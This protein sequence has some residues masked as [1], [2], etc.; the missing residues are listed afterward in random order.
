M[1]VLDASALLK[2]VVREHGWVEVERLLMRGCKTLHIA[3]AEVAMA[4]EVGVKVG[5][6]DREVALRAVKALK[7][8]VREG[9]VELLNDWEFVE[10]ATEIALEKRIPVLEAMYV[11]AA[12][13]EGA[14]ATCVRRQAVVARELG[15]EAILVA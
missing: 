14:I 4:L 15:I 8:I 2:Y 9:V 7:E 1:I 6:F 3:L 10:R 12:E 11:A 13:V 5:H